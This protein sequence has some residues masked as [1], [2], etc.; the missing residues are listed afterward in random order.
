[1]L[2]VNVSTVIRFSYYTKSIS[3]WSDLKRQQQHQLKSANNTRLRVCKLCFAPRLITISALF[4][5]SSTWIVLFLFYCSFSFF[6]NT[7]SSNKP[8]FEN[9]F[10]IFITQTAPF[11]HPVCVLFF[12]CVDDFSCSIFKTV[13]QNNALALFF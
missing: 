7:F 10:A 5:S 3:F 12:F 2:M 11:L 1:M 9:Q 8:T 6:S 4:V 13:Y